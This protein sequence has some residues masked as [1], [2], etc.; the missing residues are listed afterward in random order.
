MN[1]MRISTNMLKLYKRNQTEILEMK[2]T[3]TKIQ[4]SLEEL[5]CNFEQ[6]AK[7]IRRLESRKMKTVESME[8]EEKKMEKK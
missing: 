2:I 5:N 8:Q 7:R 4:N 1:K 6:A 3:I